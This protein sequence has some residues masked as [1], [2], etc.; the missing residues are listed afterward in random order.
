MG[1][2]K[3]NAIIVTHWQKDR[4]ETAH[5]MA[6]NIFSAAFEKQFGTK[7]GK[8]LIGNIQEGI[9]NSQFT[10]LI[11]PDGSKEGWDTSKM[12]D[13]ARASYLNW[14]RDNSLLIDYIEVQFGGDDDYEC[15]I[16]SKH[17]DLNK[18]ENECP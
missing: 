13:E 4:V 9:I 5:S 10:F 12:G 18:I 1:Y 7:N 11:A 17:I 6:I 8:C 3:H 14:L 2:I 15:I 16:R